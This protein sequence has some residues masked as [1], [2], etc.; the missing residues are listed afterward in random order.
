MDEDVPGTTGTLLAH[1]A[2]AALTVVE[3]QRVKA[4]GKASR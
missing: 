1:P 4:D 3:R 2:R